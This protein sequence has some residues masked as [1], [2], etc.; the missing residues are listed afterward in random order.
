MARR[1]GQQGRAAEARWRGGRARPV[2]RTVAWAVARSGARSETVGQQ[3]PA[4]G[5]AEGG[6]GRRRS[7]LLAVTGWRSTRAANHRV[8]APRPALPSDDR[9]GACPGRAR[10]A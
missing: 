2:R 7:G 9:R 6:A 5:D 8:W 1:R 10:A 4:G 3:P